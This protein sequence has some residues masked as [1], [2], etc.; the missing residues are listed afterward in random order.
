MAARLCG[1]VDLVIN[2][3]QMIDNVNQPVKMSRD[4]RRDMTEFLLHQRLGYR[5]SRL[6]RIMQSRL[7]AELAEHGLTRLMWTVLCGLGEDGITRPSDL[8]E[9]IGITRP[10][11]SRL[12]RTME[13]RGLVVRS[14]AEGADGRCVRLALTEEGRRIIQTSRPR[15]SAMTAHFTA[16][17]PPE[18]LALVLESLAILAE[19]EGADLTRL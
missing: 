4:G 14:E 6:A 19:G 13:E 15:V 16:K 11:T 17:L 8:A 18:R 12:L 1:H 2:D 9:Y 3:N 5:V 10:A 7:E